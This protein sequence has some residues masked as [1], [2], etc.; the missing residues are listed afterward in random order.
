[1]RND[2]EASAD[3]EKSV[4]RSE[5]DEIVRSAVDEALCAHVVWCPS[6]DD[7]KGSIP[8]PWQPNGHACAPHPVAR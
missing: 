3:G 7:A 8:N 4:H 2:R 1:M 5:T 6:G